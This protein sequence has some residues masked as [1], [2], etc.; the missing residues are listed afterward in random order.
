MIISSGVKNG[1]QRPKPHFTE[2][3]AFSKRPK[4]LVWDAW[5]SGFQPVFTGLGTLGRVAKNAAEKVE[6]NH[7]QALVLR[8]EGLM[9]H[10][11]CFNSALRNA[12][13]RP[14]T[15]E[16]TPNYVEPFGFRTAS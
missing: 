12:T 16:L 10:D 8:L 13:L 5:E 15:E 11:S 14:I 1:I 3:F 7:Q 6:P 9:A 4:G 2:V